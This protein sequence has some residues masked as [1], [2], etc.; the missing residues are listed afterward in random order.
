[1]ALVGKLKTY[2]YSISE[3]ETETYKITHPANLPPDH[4][5]F[6]KAGTTEEITVPLT[7]EKEGYIDSVYVIVHSI[8]TWKQTQG[9]SDINLMNITYRVYNSKEDR[10]KDLDSFIIEDAIIG[11]S[12][13]FESPKKETEQAYELVG[14][15]KGFDELIKI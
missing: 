1:M 2:E 14:N 9:D 15:L 5:N 8:N 13:D 3:T 12:L 10:S 4:I 6:D 7:I 11:A